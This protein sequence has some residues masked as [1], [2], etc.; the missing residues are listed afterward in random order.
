MPAETSQSPISDLTKAAL[1]MQSTTK[2]VDILGVGVQSLTPAE[3]LTCISDTIN[4]KSKALLLNVN[5]HALNLAY[6]QPWLRSYFNGAEVVFPDG[7]GA[8]WAGRLLG[9]HMYPRITYADWFYD[10]AAFAEQRGYSLYFLGARPGVT[11]NARQILMRKYPELKI[12]GAQQ[13][14]FDHGLNSE[15]SL[16]VIEAINRQRPHILVVGFGMPRQERWLR[17]HWQQIEANV[18]LTAGAVF[19]YVSGQLARPPRLLTEHGFE[20]LGR[21]F[22][23]PRRLWRRY[24]LGNPKFVLR[25]LRQRFSLG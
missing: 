18:A 9:H 13:G 21:L 8:V 25:V 4:T 5:A 1:K 20:W 12:V 2:G 23:E 6:E 7:H 14:Y 22:I 24:L 19:D 17:D 10:L 11:E 16:A 3:L 15:D